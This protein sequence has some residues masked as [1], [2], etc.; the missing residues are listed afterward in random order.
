MNADI[1]TA[2]AEITGTAIM[3]HIRASFAGSLETVATEDRPANLADADTML[4][5]H[6]FGRVGAWDLGAGGTVTARVRMVD[7]SFNGTRAARLD[8]AI[9]TTH[10]ELE[11]VLTHTVLDGD[12]VTSEP[13]CPLAVVAGSRYES[14][15]MR[16]HMVSDGK[17][18]EDRY[19]TNF[20]A[21]RPIWVARRKA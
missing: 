9:G 13:G 18:W 12:L 8:Q 4:A 1:F 6:G 17:T 20:P 11:L 7:N 15:T 19:T 5:F 3:I 10:G 14:G 21:D 16:L 2:T